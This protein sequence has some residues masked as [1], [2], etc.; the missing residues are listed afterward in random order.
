[1]QVVVFSQWTSMLDIAQWFLACASEGGSEGLPCVRLDGSLS[2]D[3][4]ERVLKGFR[5]PGGPMV[6]FASLK[7]CGVGLNLTCACCVVMLDLW[8]NPAVEAQAIDRVHRFG[9]TRPVRVWRLT[10]AGTVE[11][12][13]LA[14]QV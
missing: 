9:Q 4:R 2:R 12:K 3:A 11:G 8:W 1:L 6:V 10:V 14:M 5:S 13:L 7:A